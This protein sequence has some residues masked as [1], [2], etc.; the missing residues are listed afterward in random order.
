[1]Q[2]RKQD[3][4]TTKHTTDVKSMSIRYKLFQDV[5]NRTGIDQSVKNKKPSSHDRSIALLQSP[6]LCPITNTPLTNDNAC[7]D[8]IDPKSLY[9]ETKFSVISDVGNRK[10]SNLTKEN[11]QKIQTYV[12]STDTQEVIINVQ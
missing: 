3:V 9:G 10:K 6:S 1:M 8:H 11:L 12:E 7:I 5:L 4:E 2:A